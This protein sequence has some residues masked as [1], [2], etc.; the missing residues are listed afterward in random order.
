MPFGE[1]LFGSLRL[2]YI[3][4][5]KSQWSSAWNWI[6]W[7]ESLGHV[8]LHYNRHTLSMNCIKAL[9]AIENPIFFFTFITLAVL[10]YLHWN[11]S[12]LSSKYW[13]IWAGNVFFFL[14]SHFSCL[15]LCEVKRICFRILLGRNRKIKFRQMQLQW[16]WW[17][18]R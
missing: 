7:C 14:S 4:N 16:T 9:A 5:L 1:L 8:S 3:W 2:I 18:W 10:Y 17:W 11:E 15:L 12:T 6:E 13:I